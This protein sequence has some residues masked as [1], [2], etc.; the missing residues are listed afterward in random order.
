MSIT[1]VHV[2]GAR[3]RGLS[4]DP[5][6][7]PAPAPGPPARG[8]HGVAALR[9]AVRPAVRGPAGAR[10]EGMGNASRRSPG[11]RR[12]RSGAFPMPAQ[13]PSLGFFSIWACWRPRYVGER[14]P[15]R[16]GGAGGEIRAEVEATGRREMSTSWASRPGQV[17][18]DDGVSNRTQPRCSAPRGLDPAGPR[19]PDFDSQTRSDGATASLSPA[20]DNA[21]VNPHVNMA[22]LLKMTTRPRQG[23]ATAASAV[24]RRCW[25]C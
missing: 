25:G 13:S 24:T 16:P 15:S 23:P 3:Q 22:A 5:G 6:Q 7:A 4:E 11:P 21:D 17:A 20:T 10:R 8:R 1:A 19:C 2:P 12:D 14:P 9:T 18:D